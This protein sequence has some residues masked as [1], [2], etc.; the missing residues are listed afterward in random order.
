MH[1]TG[2][3]ALQFRN[4]PRAEI[5]A[6]LRRSRTIAV[7]GLSENATRTSHS[8]SAAMRGYG[9]RII[10]VN[11]VIR[12]ALGEPAVPDLEHVGAALRPGEQV[13]IVNVFRRPEHV[14]E[15]VDRC[16]ALR[17]PAI[18]L[19]EGV[20]DET[21][22]ERARAAGIFVVMDECIYKYRAAM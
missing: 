14:A 5:E 17:F 21:A 9:Y 20:I 15:V 18:W 10:P 22:A 4:P 19:Q 12:S 8:V 7:V 16:I 1:P 2:D 6:L 11:P 3:P 13:D